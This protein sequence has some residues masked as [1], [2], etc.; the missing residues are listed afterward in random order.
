MLVCTFSGHRIINENVVAPLVT[1]AITEL[2]RRDNEFLFYTGGMG[3]FDALCSRIVRAEKRK[4]PE[5]RL[6][7]VLVEPYM[8]SSINTNEE[9]LLTL[10]DDIEVPL[11]L[12]DCHPKA[13]IGKRNRILIDRSDYL[14][15]CVTR[16]YGGAYQTLRYA[17]KCPITTIDVSGV[18]ISE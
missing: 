10:Y 17:R 9:Q 18:T 4:H 1:A 3:D 14:I 16:Q 6:S 11:E 7:L 13:A 5:K 12:M 8:K 15:A 2:L